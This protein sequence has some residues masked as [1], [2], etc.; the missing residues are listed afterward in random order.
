MN[1]M[2]GGEPPL[3]VMLG[4]HFPRGRSHGLAVVPQSPKV[5]D[6]E[7]DKISLAISQA[8]TTQNPSL[9]GTLAGLDMTIYAFQREE[10]PPF[11]WSRRDAVAGAAVRSELTVEEYATFL[12]LMG[13]KAI[14]PES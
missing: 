9:V 7:W 4:R 3:T 6:L 11:H 1:R 5:C 10:G 14:W 13:E 2:A 8:R 12:K